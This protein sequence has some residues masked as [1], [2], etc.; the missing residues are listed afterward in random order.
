MTALGDLPGH[1]SARFPTIGYMSRMAKFKTPLVPTPKF[2]SPRIV[3]Q[4]CDDISVNG[5]VKT[6]HGAA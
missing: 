5:G 2:A 1:R 4:F 3:R 6:C